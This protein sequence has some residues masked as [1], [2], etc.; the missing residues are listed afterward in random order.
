MDCSNL[1]SK[2]IDYIDTVEGRIEEDFDLKE[3]DELEYNYLMNNTYIIS[4]KCI[5]ELNDS[6]DL[7]EELNIL[8]KNIKEVLKQMTRNQNQCNVEEEVQ[9]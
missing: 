9:L 3:I 2:I 4:M 7:E 6:M 1:K 8:D 5:R